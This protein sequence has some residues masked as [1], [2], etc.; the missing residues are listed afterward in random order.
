MD[1]ALGRAD[2]ALSSGVC[3]AKMAA[4]EKGEIRVCRG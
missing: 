3:R 4:E 2:A 1:F